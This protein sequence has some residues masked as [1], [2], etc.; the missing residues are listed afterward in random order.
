MIE[1]TRNQHYEQAMLEL[2]RR[3]TKKY[4]ERKRAE[5]AEAEK[6]SADKPHLYRVPGPAWSGSSEWN[7]AC[8]GANRIGYGVSMFHAYAVWDNPHE[9]AKKIWKRG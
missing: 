9:A 2:S 7:W 1:N 6:K 3:Q 4:W 5:Q 8:R